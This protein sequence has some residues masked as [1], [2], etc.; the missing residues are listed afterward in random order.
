[1]L[2]GCIPIITDNVDT[3]K[4]ISKELSVLINNKINYE[5]LSE[6]IIKILQYSDDQFYELSDKYR[7]FAM[8]EFNNLNQ[9]NYFKN[10]YWNK[11]YFSNIK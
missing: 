6:A 5:Q 11:D 9:I 8:S 3:K 7:K 4:I 1:M 10:L 2:C